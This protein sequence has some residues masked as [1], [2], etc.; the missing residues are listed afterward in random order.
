MK[1]SSDVRWL[2]RLDA[3]LETVLAAMSV[4]LAYDLLG[5]G[6]WRTPSW[7]STPIWLAVVLVL[8]LAAALLWWLSDHPAPAAVRAVAIANGVTTLTF[9]AWA[10]SGLGT[11]LQL[12]VLLAATAVLLGA[13]ATA[14]Y[15]RATKQPLK[16]HTP[17][18]PAPAE[19]TQPR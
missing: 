3:G 9:L 12:R 6:E 11:G 14:Q 13:L 1:T 10:I 16:A 7:L 4:V 17:N 15:T 18:P 8:L 2:L 5:T 19:P